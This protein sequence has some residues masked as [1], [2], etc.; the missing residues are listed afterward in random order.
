MLEAFLEWLGE[1]TNN[2]WNLVHHEVLPAADPQFQAIPP[3]LEP[4]VSELIRGSK[5]DSLYSHQANAVQ[6]SLD[7]RNV[8]LSTS[9][10]SGKTLAYQ[11]PVLDRLIRDPNA[12]ALFLFPLKALERDQRDAFVDLAGD[13]GVHHCGL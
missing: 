4:R 12:R 3:D 1:P 2:G 8:V 11:T 10:A 13:T 9:T 6:L 7:G 5:I